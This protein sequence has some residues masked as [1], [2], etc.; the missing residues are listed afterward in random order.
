[1]TV[2]RVVYLYCDGP[3][4]EEAGMGDPYRIDAPVGYTATKQRR[5]AKRVDGWIH[6]NGKDY[7]RDCAKELGLNRRTP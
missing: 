6:R 4:C 5:D 7:C 2:R 3:L 1:M